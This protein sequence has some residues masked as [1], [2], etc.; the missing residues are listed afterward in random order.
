MV[1]LLSLITSNRKE[2]TIPIKSSLLSAKKVMID[3]NSIVKAMLAFVNADHAMD[4]NLQLSQ[5][6]QE[7]LASLGSEPLLPTINR[8]TTDLVHH[9][10]LS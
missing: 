9:L 7:I 8:L 10:K 1:Q 5:K 2:K 3:L 4:W 6:E